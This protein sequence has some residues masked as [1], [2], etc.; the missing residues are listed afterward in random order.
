MSV[1]KYP[2]FFKG[3]NTLKYLSFINEN[4]TI[5]LS[6]FENLSIHVKSF[7]LQKFRTSNFLPEKDHACMFIYLKSKNY[8]NFKA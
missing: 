2:L 6:I 1:K 5:R 3:G 8:W 7:N 4:H